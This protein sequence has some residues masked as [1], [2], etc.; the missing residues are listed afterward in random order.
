MK[1]RH[2][3]SVILLFTVCAT[4][5]GC[6]NCFVAPLTRVEVPIQVKIETVRIY[7]CG[8]VE[9]EGYYNVAIGT[10]YVEVLRLAG[11]LPESV[12][13]TLSS[14]Y[15]DGET[16]FVIVNYCDET[17]HYSINANSIL[18]ASR[19]PVNGLSDDVVN[20]LADYI[21][22]HGKIANKLQLEQALGS[23]YADNY[24]KLFIAEEDYEKAD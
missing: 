20:K 17:F 11:L 6:G 4:L 14:S 5:C 16:K 1:R 8:A 21:D 19:L 9:R 3:T 2:L 18:I 23:D 15:V 24:Y 13:P 12:M 10:D 22:A 7:I